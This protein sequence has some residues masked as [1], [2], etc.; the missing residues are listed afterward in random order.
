[1]GSKGA[2]NVARAF[3]YS[4]L[5]RDDKSATASRRASGSGESSNW[6]GRKLCCL[7]HQ[8]CAAQAAS[9]SAQHNELAC[10]GGS[11][12]ACCTGRA[13]SGTWTAG[14]CPGIPGPAARSC[15]RQWG[16]LSTGHA[17]GQAL[18]GSQLDHRPPAKSAS[19]K[20]EACIKF[21]HN[22]VVVVVVV[23]GCVCGGG[24]R[25]GGGGGI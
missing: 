12:G 2:L 1:M 22:R 16:Q 23:V 8:P 5:H 13:G 25:G 7:E 4:R 20:S 10:P 17:F 6:A 9:R 3:Y 19:A 14:P 24:G 15:G 11:P 21:C 18:L